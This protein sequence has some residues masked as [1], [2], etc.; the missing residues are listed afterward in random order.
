M[1]SSEHIRWWALKIPGKG[2]AFVMSLF[3][4][5]ENIFSLLSALVT[6]NTLTFDNDST[7]FTKEFASV[8]IALAVILLIVPPIPSTDPLPWLE[9]NKFQ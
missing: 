4:P 2:S 1:P 5:K 9:A 7:V 3:K 6:C 8:I